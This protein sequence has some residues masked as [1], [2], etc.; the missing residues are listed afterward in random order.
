MLALG[1]PSALP[2]FSLIAHRQG[3]VLCCAALHGLYCAAS[4]GP[5]QH[6]CHVPGH[7][8]PAEELQAVLDLQLSLGTAS[9]A[10]SGEAGDLANQRSL[11]SNPATSVFGAQVRAS[12]VCAGGCSE[13][14][15]SARRCCAQLLAGK[16][17][18]CRPLRLR[19][20]PRGTHP[21]AGAAGAAAGDCLFLWGR[22]PPGIL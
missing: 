15:H 3:A 7:A 16:R 13:S 12:A 4:A 20:T 18:C 2:C 21:A 1:V 17:Y 6:G 22:A 5:S 9:R 14:K 11:L 10:G 8:A 19:A